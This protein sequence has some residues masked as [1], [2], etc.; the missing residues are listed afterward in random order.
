MTIDK[1]KAYDSAGAPYQFKIIRNRKDGYTLTIDGNFY[2]TA[3]SRRDAEDEIGHYISRN[4]LS[5]TKPF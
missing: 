4:S 5:Y 3:E 1:M 2:A